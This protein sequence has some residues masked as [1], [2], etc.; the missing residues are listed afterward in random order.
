MGDIAGNE[1][2]IAEATARRYGPQRRQTYEEHIAERVEAARKAN[3]SLEKTRLETALSDYRGK[4][5]ELRQKL[6]HEQELAASLDRRLAQ[7]REELASA[8][9]ALRAATP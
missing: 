8:E 2:R 9:A 1:R 5:V 7:A 3:D 6:A 4:L